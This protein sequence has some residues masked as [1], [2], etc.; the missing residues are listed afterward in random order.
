M[1]Q[2]MQ[3]LYPSGH[4][5]EIFMPLR[6]DERR[7]LDVLKQAVDIGFYRGV[8]LG[9][10]FDKYNRMAVRNII[11][12]NGYNLTI[13]VTP[14]LKENGMNLSSLDENLRNKT[15]Q[16]TIDLI[17]LASEM[18]C[19]NLGVPSGD[20]PGDA[21]RKKAKQVLAESMAQIADVAKAKS[22]NITLE[23]LDR[24]AYKKQLIGPM[25]ETTDWFAPLHARCPNTFIHWDSAHEALSQTDIM[26]SLEY[27]SPYIAQFHL[28]NAILDRFHPC[29]GDLHMDVE[30]PPEFET[31]GFL[32]PNIGAQILAKVASFPKPAGVERTFVSIEVMGHPGD[33]L[34]HK[35][36]TSRLFLQKCF[37]LAGLEES[38]LPQ[39]P[40]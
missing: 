1:N 39:S 15:I 3:T 12:Q 18:G 33:D 28:C 40:A 4:L 30:Q 32:T 17:E 27:A 22:M 20:D 8:E 31:E 34:W 29:F 36:E 38:L 6:K 5:L 7:M 10:F 24:Y 26:L 16:Y 25:K 2:Q 11:E 13:F 19:T 9:I 14:Y 35:E 37:A 23:P 21:L